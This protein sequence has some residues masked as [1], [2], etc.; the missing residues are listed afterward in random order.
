MSDNEKAKCHLYYGGVKGGGGN[1]DS[2]RVTDYARAIIDNDAI[3]A[4]KTDV[5][6]KQLVE[7]MKSAQARLMS[8]LNR[9][10]YS[11]DFEIKPLTEEQL[12]EFHK[13]ERIRK[14]L[15]PW[16]WL[17]VRLVGTYEVWRYGDTEAG[18]SSW[19]I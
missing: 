6:F 12:K 2:K 10:L 19:D 5:E 1:S 14:L 17:K 18:R 16:H 8:N 4:A 13:K 7:R 3:N 11:G 15:A 9:E